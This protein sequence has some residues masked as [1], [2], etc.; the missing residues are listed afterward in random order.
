MT[1]LDIMY[2][3]ERAGGNPDDWAP[4]NPISVP[5][6]EDL[7]KSLENALPWR[8]AGDGDPAYREVPG[9]KLEA[10]FRAMPVEDPTIFHG[11]RAP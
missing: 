8:P 5:I 6:N 10:L 2:G 11:T 9:A 4:D 7:Y 3:G 1:S